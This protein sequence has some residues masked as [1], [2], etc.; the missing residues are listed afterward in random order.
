MANEAGKRYRCAKCGSEMI[1]VRGGQGTLSCCGEPMGPV[2]QVPPG[3]QPN[4]EGSKDAQSA[5]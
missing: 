3:R 4:A 2:V 5:R 1:V